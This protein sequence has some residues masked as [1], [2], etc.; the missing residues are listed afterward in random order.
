MT[1]LK[2]VFRCVNGALALA[3]LVWLAGCAKVNDLGLMAV[4]TSPSGYLLVS[5]QLL[6]GEVVLVPDRTGRVSFAST[7]AG[8]LS[9]AGGMRYTATHGGTVDLRC[10]DGSE[11]GIQVSMLSET[12]GFGYGTLAG[13]TVSLVFGLSGADARA[14]LRLPPG[15]SLGLKPETGDLD[16]K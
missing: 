11:V 2:T 13:Q 9:C 6:K 12:K 15:M 14:Y 16:L 4:S 5:G 1:Q 7:A 8:G 3:G 10:N